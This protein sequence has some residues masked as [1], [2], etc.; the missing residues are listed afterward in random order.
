MIS[1]DSIAELVQRA[2]EGDSTAWNQLVDRY[3]PLVMSVMRS[4]RLGDKDCED[5]CQ[6]VWLRLVENLGR[7]REPRA[8]PAWIVRTTKNEALRVSRQRL[9]SV[10]V[11]VAEG[12]LLDRVPDAAELDLHLLQAERDQAIRDGL[13]MLSHQQ[14]QLLLLL[15][16]DPPVPYESIGQ[17]LGMA[18]GSIGPTRARCLEK[19]RSTPAL[20]ALLA[21]EHGHHDRGGARHVA[22]TVGA[23]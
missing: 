3:L 6:T 11:D 8:I 15:V 10:P 18:V 4:Y 9:K 14:R 1:D 7:I 21:A 5:V 19:L 2:N 20:Q 23:K 12:S 22:A 13:A 17:Q 16:A